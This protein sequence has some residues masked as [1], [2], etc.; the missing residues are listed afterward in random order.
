MS[1]KLNCYDLESSHDHPTA[2]DAARKSTF[3]PFNRVFPAY[4][5]C[6]DHRRTTI[7]KEETRTSKYSSIIDSHFFVRL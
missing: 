6:P 7:S 3:D 1:S 4:Q 5:E 2:Q